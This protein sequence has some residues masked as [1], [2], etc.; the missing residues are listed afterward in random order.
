MGMNIKNQPIITTYPYLQNFETNDGFFFAEGTNSSWQYGTPSSPEINHAASGTKAWKTS[1]SGNYNKQEFSYLYSPC[2]DISQLAKPHLSF[3]LATDI[4]ARYDVGFVEYSHDGYTWKRLGAVGQGTN[5]YNSV[6]REAWSEPGE[7]YWHVATI[8]LPKDG[9][10]ISFRFVMKSD[11]GEEHEGMAIDDIH[12]YNL[13]QTIFDQEKF[14]NPISLNVDPAASVS[15]MSFGYI[16]VTLNNGSTALG[17]TAVQDYKHTGFVNVDSTQYY[18]PKNFTIQ[19]TNNPGDSV[20]VRFYVPDEGMRLIREDSGCMSCSKVREVQGLGISKYTDPDRTKENNLLSDNLNGTWTFIPKNKIT[21]VPY[22][23]GYYAEVKVK[24][25]S[26]FWFND[27][28]PTKDQTINANLFD[29]AASHYGTRHALLNWSSMID[30]QIQKYELQRADSSM[31][32]API[33]IVNAVGQ[34]GHSYNYIDTPVLNGPIV[35]YRIKYTMQDGSQHLSVIRSLDWTGSDAIVQIYPNPVRNGLLTLEWFKGNG[36]ALEWGMYN[37]AGQKVVLGNT[38]L[39]GYNGKHTFE[40]SKM[41]LAS[42]MY[43][44]RV[45]SGK[46]K[47]EFK[48]VYQ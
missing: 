25:F 26:E 45:T 1:L 43:I 15:F 33:G 12:V 44:L 34:N 19:P 36:D 38:N 29:F 24:S 30:A 18:L 11:Q 46:D 31:N 5:W 39:N 22:D 2:F 3:S 21:W 32:F 14:A 20:T 41:G 47:W 8:P 23:I 10:I 9:N 28:G 13:G 7:N 16:G 37:I 4:E 27:G 17:M 40:L 6:D 48:V 42:G 35:H